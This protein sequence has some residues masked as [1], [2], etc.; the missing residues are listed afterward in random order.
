MVVKVSIDDPSI[1][2]TEWLPSGIMVHFTGGSS[3]F[4]PTEFLFNHRWEQKPPPEPVDS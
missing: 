1:T 4:F 3:A 2:C